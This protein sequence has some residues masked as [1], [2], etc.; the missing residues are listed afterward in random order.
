MPHRQQ[1][2]WPRR[3]GRVDMTARNSG[4]APT[5]ASNHGELCR[6]TSARGGAVAAVPTCSQL[7]D[8]L[9]DICLNRVVERGSK[10]VER[11]VPALQCALGS[12]A[13]TAQN[14]Q[15]F[16]FYSV[17]DS[18]CGVLNRWRRVRCAEL[19]NWNLSHPLQRA[20]GQGRA[21]TRMLLVRQLAGC[22]TAI[23]HQ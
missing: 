17:P 16:F 2:E 5:G 23:P 15:P 11:L 14:P 4:G 8:G 10:G 21:A 1:A 12:T 18:L 19:L 3:G 22:N 20:G 13:Y 6:C 7:L 9:Q